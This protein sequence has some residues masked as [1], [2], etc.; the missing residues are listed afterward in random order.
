MMMSNEYLDTMQAFFRNRPRLNNWQQQKADEAKQSDAYY[1]AHPLT[2]QNQARINQKVERIL[3]ATTELDQASEQAAQSTEVAVGSVAGL[4]TLPV[5]MGLSLGSTSLALNALM[6]TKN[7]LMGLAKY[8]SILGAGVIPILA[9][10]GFSAIWGAQQ[11]TRASR[12]ARRET[13]QG[14]LANPN[15]Y[16]LFTE[17]QK[18]VALQNASHIPNE[19]IEAEEKAKNAKTDGIG[20]AFHQLKTLVTD[21]H[22]HE[23]DDLLNEVNDRL[24]KPAQAFSPQSEKDLKE[25]A[26][27]VSNITRTINDRSESYTE[28]VENAYG[29]LAMGF[30]A[31]VGLPLSI[32]LAHLFSKTKIGKEGGGMLQL[33]SGAASLFLLNTPLLFIG[34]ALER[35]GARVAR[36]KT[37]QDMKNNPNSLLAVPD[38]DKASVRGI[39][40]ENFKPKGI[41]DS[42]KQAFTL[43]FEFMKDHKAYQAWDKTEGMEEKKRRK[44]LDQIQL[45]PEQVEDA[46]RLQARTHEAFSLT[47]E[48]SQDSEMME[49][50]T[51]TLKQVAAEIPQLALFAP[52]AAVVAGHYVPLPKVKWLEEAAKT[53]GVEVP[54]SDAKGW[55]P[56]LNDWRLETMGK[57]AQAFGM[58]KIEPITTFLAKPQAE[59]EETLEGFQKK[60]DKLLEEKPFL[61][62]FKQYGEN[63]AKDALKLTEEMGTTHAEKASQWTKWIQEGYKYKTLRN[64]GVGVVGTLAVGGLAVLLGPVLLVNSIFTRWQKDSMRVGLMQADDAMKHPNFFKLDGEEKRNPQKPSMA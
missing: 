33:A 36:W 26:A 47:D 7:R 4:V 62:P 63:L 60:L 29:T 14:E 10:E 17:E 58:K 54:K 27:L 39:K 30:N 23:R 37:R 45:S 31:V 9:L 12:I 43:P 6:N 53:H 49:A 48:Y 64:T 44:A 52:A 46:K 55:E 20:G 57:S 41:W 16:A 40:D 50:S 8:W 13:R 28:N 24:N 38:E 21:K 19:A 2:P 11:E 56:L 15:R 42:F 32:G 59:Q 34:N 35:D 18:Q 3:N 61:K 22:S 5:V 25:D 1:K 51:D